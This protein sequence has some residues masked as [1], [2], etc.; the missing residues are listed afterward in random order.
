VLALEVSNVLHRHT[1]SCYDD[2]SGGGYYGHRRGYY[3]ARTAYGGIGFGWIV[4][5]FGLL[6][7]MPHWGFMGR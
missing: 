4:I 6:F 1:I 5:L 7:L 3:D 2:V